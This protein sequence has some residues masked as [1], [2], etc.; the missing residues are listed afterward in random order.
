M[1]EIFD[2]SE[3][4]KLD[5]DTLNTYYKQVLFLSIDAHLGK[6]DFEK[7]FEKLIFQMPK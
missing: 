1:R 6:I 3:M 4:F 7:G 2:A 5:K